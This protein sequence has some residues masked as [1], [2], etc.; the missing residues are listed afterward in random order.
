MQITWL[1]PLHKWENEGNL[2]K[3]EL[4]HEPLLPGGGD[5]AKYFSVEMMTK[6]THSTVTLW[7]RVIS[8]CHFPRQCL[9]KDSTAPEGSAHHHL[10]THSTPHAFSHCCLLG[11]TICIPV[12][13]SG[14]SFVTLPG[15]KFHLASSCGQSRVAVAE[16]S[17][18]TKKLNT[19][20]LCWFK[21]W[22]P[23]HTKS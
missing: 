8:V 14:V 9:H 6:N 15:N 22:G 18:F 23:E 21:W 16:P 7:A 11:C 2:W 5:S 13:E 3:A 17:L 12:W 19:R 10:S 4:S 20:G 1:P